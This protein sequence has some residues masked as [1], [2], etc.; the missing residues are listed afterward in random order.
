MRNRGLFLALLLLAS[1]LLWAAW[2]Y[3]DDLSFNAL[4]RWGWTSLTAVGVVSALWN[5]REALVDN[6]A[7]SQSPQ[8]GIEVLRMQTR[9]S[10]WDHALILAALAGNL[11]AGVCSLFGFATGAL[12]SLLLSAGLLIYLSFS[13]TQRRRRLFDVLRLRRPKRSKAD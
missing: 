1:V 11:I 9:N 6:W 4:I 10:I 8:G 5:L 7:L 2:P 3:L 12:L 13:Q